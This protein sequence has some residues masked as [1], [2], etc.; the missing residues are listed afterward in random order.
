MSLDSRLEHLKRIVMVNGI[1]HK[2]YMVVKQLTS[3]N[4]PCKNT[5]FM[6]NK[7]LILDTFFL[8]R[9]IVKMLGINH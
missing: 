1:M 2:L 4:L 6:K 9:Q 3:H 8:N 5:R 7:I